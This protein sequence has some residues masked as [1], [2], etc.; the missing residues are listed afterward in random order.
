M[1]SEDAILPALPSPPQTLDG[2]LK[3]LSLEATAERHL[4]SSS[5]LSFAKLTQTVLRR[6]TPDRADF[7]FGNDG[8][9][10]MLAGLNIVSPSD[11]LNSPMFDNLGVSM[12]CDPAWVNDF[13]FNDITEPDHHLANLSIPTDQSHI[14]SLVEFYFAHSHTLYPVVDRTEVL[15]TLRCVREEPQSSWAQSP[16]CLFRIW[17]V[18]AIGSTAYC[19]ISLADESESMLYYNK[20]LTYFESALGLGDMVSS[21]TPPRSTSDSPFV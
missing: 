9:Q 18:L 5:G 8:D 3:H 20:A 13:V 10:D 4:G 6:L 7:V 14:N 15:S 19:S 1:P 17:M 21:T 16:L 2:E 11:L 12:P